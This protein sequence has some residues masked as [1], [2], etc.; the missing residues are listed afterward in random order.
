MTDCKIFLDQNL[1]ED[2]QFSVR[3]EFAKHYLLTVRRLSAGDRIEVSGS[4]RVAQV[5]LRSQDPL[6]VEIDSVRSVQPVEWTLRIYQAITRK[7]KFEETIKR[8]TELG[9]TRFVPVITDRTVRVPN[10]PEK[11]R[12][13]WRKIATDSARISQRDT[14]P[15]IREPQ[16]FENVLE[17]MDGR[18]YRADPT[19]ERMNDVVEREDDATEPVSIIVG[20]EGGFTE[21]EKNQL[22]SVTTGTVRAGQRN[23]RA[24]TAS[25]ALISLWLGER[26]YL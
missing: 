10:N 24:E 6:T 2:G 4:N 7:N 8:G 14:V 23:L 17:S 11:Q 19:G 3:D 26:G 1:P 18:A 20:P 25:V 21:D 12:R 9:V 22:D 16:P 5:T 13:R 15:A